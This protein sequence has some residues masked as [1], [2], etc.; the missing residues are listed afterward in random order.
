MN[1]QNGRMLIPLKG[2]SKW[3]DCHCETNIGLWQGKCCIEY[4]LLC[5]CKILCYFGFGS[6]L[7]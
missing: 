3:G 1:V 2:E 6:S 4:L 7:F 5:H